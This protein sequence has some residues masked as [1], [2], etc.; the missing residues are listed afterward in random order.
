MTNSSSN[1]TIIETRGITKIYKGN[2]VEVRAV[3]GIDYNIAEDVYL[4]A[5]ATLGIG[6]RPYRENPSADPL[7]RSEFGAYPNMYW[8]SFRVYF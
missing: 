4:A 6:R 5:G 2:G 8:A 1:G 3:R 7:L